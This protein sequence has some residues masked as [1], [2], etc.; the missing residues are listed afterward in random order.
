MMMRS[1]IFYFLVLYLIGGLF[2][3]LFKKRLSISYICAT[4]FLWGTLIFVI[5]TI[6]ILSLSIPYTKTT[7]EILGTSM[8][9]LLVG[10]NWKRQTWRLSKHEWLVVVVITIF[11]ISEAIL[12]DIFN[13]TIV[14]ND[15][16]FLINMARKMAAGNIISWLFASP[17]DYG[18]FIPAIQ[19]SSRMWGLDYFPALE[20]IFALVFLL[21]FF[22]F[23]HRL[24]RESVASTS[25]R[26]I[27]TIFT[28]LILFSTPLIF[29]NIFYIHTNL[30]AAAFFFSAVCSFWLGI[31]ENSKPLL[32][33]GLISLLGFSLCRPE[34]PLF[35]LTF[36]VILFSQ[37]QISYRRRIILGIPYAISMI[38]WHWMINRMVTITNAEMMS[39]SVLSLY[40][41]F[42]IVFIVWVVASKIPWI[43]RHILPHSHVWVLAILAVGLFTAFIIKRADMTVNLQNSALNLFGMG[44][45]GT[46]G[47]LIIAYLIFS[48]SRPPIPNERLF[49]ATILAFFFLTLLLGALREPYHVGWTDS[50]NRMFFHVIPIALIYILLKFCQGAFFQF[51]VSSKKLRKRKLKFLPLC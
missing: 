51:G 24:T 19:S 49:S 46:T 18:I 1:E 9:V 47:L 39:P 3:L 43:E 13:F 25:Q 8:L 16:I 33:L 27:L 30:S 4:G 15:S 10:L 6:T 11:F 7:L 35:A 48:I 26:V 36:L 34:G 38:L 22:F 32:F 17:K 44:W 5:G 42:F 40:I 20:P 45:W 28:S 21:I 23:C 12:F 2:G 50:A 31:R 41:S 37:K 29:L 14:T